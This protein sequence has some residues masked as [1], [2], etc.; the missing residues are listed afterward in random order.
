[1]LIPGPNKDEKKADYI[2]RCMEFFEKETNFD[3]KNKEDKKQALDICNYKF[4]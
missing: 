2:K 3:L 1:M 4:K